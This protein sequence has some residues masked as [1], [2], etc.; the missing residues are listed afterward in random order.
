MRIAALFAL[1]AIA[2]CAPKEEEAPPPPATPT[3][4]DF[5]GTWN[6]ASVLEGTPDTV[7]TSITGAADGAWTL[8]LEG[9]PPVPLTVSMS[10]DSLVSQSAEYESVLRQGVMVTVRTAGVMMGNMMHGNLEATYKTGDST[11]VVKG[12][13]TGTKAP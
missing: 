2:A 10:G 9:R 3:V 1:V 6:L 12:T 8:T 7:R 11:Q 13:F 5:A 4:A